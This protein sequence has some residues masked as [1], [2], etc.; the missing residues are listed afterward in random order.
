MPNFRTK[1]HRIFKYRIIGCFLAQISRNQSIVS[2]PAICRVISCSSGPQ[3]K[4]M[5]IS[6]SE[7]S[8]WSSCREPTA[9]PSAI[10]STAAPVDV[11]NASALPHAWAVD[12]SVPGCYNKAI[13]FDDR[14]ALRLSFRG[15][16]CFF[17]HGASMKPD[18]LIS[19]GE[20]NRWKR[21][22]TYS[23]FCCRWR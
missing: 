4:K 7:G 12:K 13:L 16:G 8:A 10:T 15:K 9:F 18:G 22:W 17:H 6:V 21:Q 1:S 14:S 11:P 23:A 19:K 5:P 2:R 20:M 3:Q